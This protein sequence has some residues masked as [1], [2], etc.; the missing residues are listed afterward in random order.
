[1]YTKTETGPLRRGRP[2]PPSD[3][4]VAPPLS[5]LVS[6]A[7]TASCCVEYLA[8]HLS[9]LLHGFKAL[10]QAS[11]TLATL[12]KRKQQQEHGQQVG[13]VAQCMGPDFSK[14]EA[15]TCPW[16]RFGAHTLPDPVGLHAATAPRP[17]R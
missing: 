12:P 11:C 10:R 8:L 4:I 16:Q 15:L 9:D 7:R 13:A 1:M 5:K 14:L 17:S 6:I 2:P 3:A